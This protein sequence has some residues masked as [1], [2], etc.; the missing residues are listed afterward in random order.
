MKKCKFKKR[1]SDLLNFLAE[2]GT[3]VTVIKADTKQ[4]N[5][6]E[7]GVISRTYKQRNSA[8]KRIERLI[9]EKSAE[10]KKKIYNRCL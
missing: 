6:I 7:N 5:F 3:L 10:N 9:F 1:H 2:F 4:Y 8:N